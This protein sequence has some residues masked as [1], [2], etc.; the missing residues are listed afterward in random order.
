MQC[1]RRCPHAST[2]L[3]PALQ[4]HLREK[5]ELFEANNALRQA[6]RRAGWGEARLDAELAMIG[7][8]VDAMRAQEAGVTSVLALAAQVRAWKICCSSTYPQRGSGCCCSA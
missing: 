3:P 4:V 5:Q 2:R 1:R 6:L 7:R 8:Q